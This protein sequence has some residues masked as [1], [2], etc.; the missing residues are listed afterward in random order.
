MTG[1]YRT[2]LARR[3]VDSYKIILN[4]NTQSGDIVTLYEH[5]ETL[6]RTE[7]SIRSK[8]THTHC[9]QGC[10]ANLLWKNFRNTMLKSHLM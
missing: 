1:C 10:P 3:S 2:K 4:Q 7:D 6:A 5:N 9:D 8:A